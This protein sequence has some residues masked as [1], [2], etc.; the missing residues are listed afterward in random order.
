M[1]TTPQLEVLCLAG[2]LGRGAGDDFSDYDFVGV[3]DPAERAEVA[4]RFRTACEIL[5]P[6]VLWRQMG[7]PPALIN[8][9]LQDWTRIDLF[10]TDRAAF[11]RRAQTD[12]L[13]LHDPDN[14]V[15]TLPQVV[16]APD[17]K[18]RVAYAI[19]EF[20]RVLGLISVVIGRGELHTAI[21]GVALEKDQL[22][23]IMQVTGGLDSAGGALHLSKTLL[24][25]DMEAL[26][27]LPYPGPDPDEI[28][29]SHFAMARA[30]FPRARA[31]AAELDLTWP[32]AFEAATR[33]L[34]VARFGPEAGAC[35]VT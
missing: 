13:V 16:P 9:I 25:A 20:I 35:F 21:W 4:K 22:I 33:D 29:A 14:I 24:P 28:L 19:E 12:L 34:L 8:A 5:Q 30:F 26:M 27:A 18:G 31:L 10:M 32:T 2:S 15:A 11:E 6:V 1:Q 3:V 17:P 23:T 7:R